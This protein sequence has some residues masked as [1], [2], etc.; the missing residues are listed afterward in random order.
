MIRAVVFDLDGTLLYTLQDLAEASNYALRVQGMQEH[1]IEEYK[2]IV[3]DGRRNQM[4]R[5]LPADRRN[6]EALLQKTTE[7]FSEYYGAHMTDTT[8]PFDGI[9][10]MLAS[11]KEKGLRLGVVSNKP[12]EFTKKIVEQYFPGMF[13]CVIGQQ[14]DLIKPDPTGLNQAVAAFGLHSDE[15]LYVGDGG[16]DITTADN[17][18][19]VSCGALWGYRGQDELE[20]AG[21]K[22]MAAAPEEIVNCVMNINRTEKLRRIFASF[23][24]ALI[25]LFLV[26]LFYFVFTGNGAG[27]GACVGLTLLVGFSAVGMLR[28]K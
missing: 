1:S 8:R 25:L 23:A 2:H 6:D 18:H 3:G 12:A 17:A 11:L 7:L 22:L 5:I 15:V 14:G 16:V 9:A 19:T 28:R 24:L 21:A 10:G 13:D 4:L 26:G 20:A 27:I